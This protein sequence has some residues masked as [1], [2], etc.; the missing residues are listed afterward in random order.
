MALRKNFKPIDVE[1]VV[2]DT[3]KSPIRRRKTRKSTSPAKTSRPTAPR[4]TAPKAF[5]DAAVNKELAQQKGVP[6][7]RSPL[8]GVSKARSRPKSAM[9]GRVRIAPHTNGPVLNNCNVTSDDSSTK[10]WNNSINCPQRD[11]LIIEQD[12]LISKYRYDFN[13]CQRLPSS[14]LDRVSD[15]SGVHRIRVDP[16]IKANKFPNQPNSPSRWDAGLWDVRTQPIEITEEYKHFSVKDKGQDAFLSAFQISPRELKDM[17]IV[18]N[19][20]LC[21]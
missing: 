5:E 1:F 4:P 2:K 7:Q 8:S 3:D 13:Q 10:R 17:V 12:E 21:C 20:N 14:R 11:I 19:S 6:S 9:N 16:K 15:A 18:A